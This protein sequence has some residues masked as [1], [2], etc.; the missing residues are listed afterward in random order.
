MGELLALSQ[1]E[2]S[3]LPQ[4]HYILHIYI[5]VEIHDIYQV[6][7][8]YSAFQNLYIP[9]NYTDIFDLIFI[10]HFHTTC[11]IKSWQDLCKNVWTSCE[12]YQPWSVCL[13]R[14]TGTT[15]TGRW[16]GDFG[17][18]SLLKV[19]FALNT[20]AS[21]FHIWKFNPA[22]IPCNKSARI[23]VGV[24][25]L[26]HKMGIWGVSWNTSKCILGASCLQFLIFFCT[27]GS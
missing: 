3:P 4:K 19:H 9:T 15:Q 22:E 2:R 12:I 14:C 1:S 23:Q 24:C 27:L 20:E 21:E 11:T 5:F 13:P 6:L 7:L 10:L 25:K 16:T 17:A 8:V 18:H 26:V